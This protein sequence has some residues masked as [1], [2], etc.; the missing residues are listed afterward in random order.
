MFLSVLI[1]LGTLAYIIWLSFSK[2][3]RAIKLR[4]IYI[5][6][7]RD[8]FDSTALWHKLLVVGLLIPVINVGVA[9][10]ATIF[11]AGKKVITYVY[12]NSQWSK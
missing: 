10:I 12:L 9:I 8:Y 3:E 7:P 2:S 5:E 11:F 6:N 1:I 4:A